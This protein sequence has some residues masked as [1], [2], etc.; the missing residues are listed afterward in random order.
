MELRER[1]GVSNIS[2]LLF[3]FSL[4][5]TIGMLINAIYNIVTRIFIGNSPDLATNGLAAATVSFPVIMIIMAVSLMCGVGGATVFS[6]ALGKKEYEKVERILAN[7]LSLVI[8]STGILSIIFLLFL[9]PILML[10]GASEIVLPYAKDYMMFVLIG[11]VFQGITM[12]GNNLIRADGSPKIAM[13]SVLLGSVVNI[14]LHYVFIFIFQWGMIGAGLATVGGLLSSSIW[15]LYYF[16]FGKSN[17]NLVFK[18]MAIKKPLA[19]N[20]MII[21]L[22]SFFIQFS[23]SVWNTVLNSTLLDYGGDIAI[24]AMGIVATFQTL[25]LMPIIGINQGALPIIGYNYGAKKFGRV[26]E[27]VKKAA[28]IATIISVSGYTLIQFFPTQIISLFNQD[29]K[30]VELGVYMLTTW[31]MVLPIVGINMV[32]ANYFQ[33]IGKVKPAIFLTISRQIIIL[34]PAI[35]ILSRLFGLKGIVH[36]G[37]VADSLST[38]LVLIFIYFAFKNLGK[39]EHTEAD[40]ALEFETGDSI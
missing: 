19:L 21:G 7:S 22:P 33:A 23:N 12:W 32:G 35:L 36:A 16:I 6:I 10:F 26:K 29:P 38:I 30:L 20:I 4:P 39:D 1:L 40:D 18:K 28:I 8:L 9:E 24:S 17:T 13:Y 3:E 14:I 5:A 34:L 11:G 25:L 31:F 27:T 37:P 15:V 2:R